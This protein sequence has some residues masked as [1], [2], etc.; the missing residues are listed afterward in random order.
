MGSKISE[1]K[2]MEADAETP[3]ETLSNEAQAVKSEK[4]TTEVIYQ[5]SKEPRIFP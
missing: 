3:N 4:V 1:V 2:P 5:L